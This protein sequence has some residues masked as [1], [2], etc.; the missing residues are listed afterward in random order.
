ML[1]VF[2]DAGLSPDEAA[3]LLHILSACV[4]G[5]GFATLWGRQ[6]A[7]A[8][9]GQRGTAAASAGRPASRRPRPPDAGDLARV[10]GRHG[11]VGPRA[12]R[13]AVDIVLGAYGDGR[14]RSPQVLLDSDERDAELVLELLDAGR[15]ARRR[16]AR[17]P[18]G[19]RRRRESVCRCPWRASRSPRSGPGR[20]WWRGCTAW[21]GSFVRGWTLASCLPTRTGRQAV[22]AEPPGR[23]PLGHAARE[24]DR[25][26]RSVSS[27]PDRPL[28]RG[29]LRAR[30]LEPRVALAEARTL[31]E[32]WSSRQY[33][34]SA[35]AKSP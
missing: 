7:A 29:E 18:S 35:P 13:P 9:A 34:Q 5:F 26:R 21:H 27:S 10:R 3:E 2:R 8:R 15:S 24:I 22:D 25:I 33:F 14:P 17:R 16:W 31:C 28:R 4:V 20:A 19:G 30:H 12:V 11:A 6:I 23:D 1:G 32:S